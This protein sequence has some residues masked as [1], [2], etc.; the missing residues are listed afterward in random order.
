MT[1]ERIQR[2]VIRLL[3]EAE[4]AVEARDWAVVGQRARD[5]LD[6]DPANK[7]AEA[8]LAAADRAL[9]REAV[10]A[11]SGA[12]TLTPTLSSFDFPQDSPSSAS[13]QGEGAASAT[14]GAG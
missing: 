10:V 2:Q 1:S 13:G 12:A 6:L 4:A 11:E 3:D 7:E 5:A 9:A 14:E 8:L